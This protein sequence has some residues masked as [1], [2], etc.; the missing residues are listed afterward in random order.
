MIKES[1]VETIDNGVASHC[2][3]VDKAIIGSMAMGITLCL[4][5]HQVKHFPQSATELRAMIDLH[6]NK[7]IADCLKMNSTNY[8]KTVEDFWHSD[9]VPKLADNNIPLGSPD[10]ENI[11]SE[12]TG[13]F[14]TAFNEVEGAINKSSDKW[15]SILDTIFAEANGLA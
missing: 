10:A 12:V 8:I 7:V 13:Q 6:F 9:I 2:L 15:K 4:L 11:K 14:S 3:E 1:T 5:A